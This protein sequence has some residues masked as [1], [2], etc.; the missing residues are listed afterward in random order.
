MKSAS[1]RLCVS[2]AIVLASLFALNV[3]PNPSA[4]AH[5]PSSEISH[6]PVAKTNSTPTIHSPI[7]TKPILHSD[8]TIDIGPVVRNKTLPLDSTNAPRRSIAPS[9]TVS[10]TVGMTR[11][12]VVL[13]DVFGRYRLADY[14]VRLISDTVEVWVQ[15]DL[16]YRNLDGSINVIHPDSR[17]PE[18][19]TQAKIE[20]LAK[21]TA[22]KIIPTDVDYFGDYD[23]RDGSQSALA[24]QLGFPDGY[25]S[26]PGKRVIILVSNVR[27]GNFYDPVNNASFIAG[28]YSGQVNAFADRNII[29]IRSKQWNT[30]VGS[31]NFDYDSTIAHEFQHL[32]N[33]DHDPDEDSWANEGASEFAEFINGYRPSIDSHRTEFSDYPENS[34]TLWGDQDN[35]PDQ[36]FEI[37]ADYQE[38]YWFQLYLAGRLREAGIGT[39][40]NQFL[41]HVSQ[42][43]LDDR[44]GIDAVNAMLTSVGAPFNFAQVWSD[45][46]SAMLFGGTSDATSWGNYISQYVAPSGVPIAP[47]DLGR[48]RRNL[49]FEGYDTEGAPPYGS[50]YIEI[51]WSPAINA[52]TLLT[53]NG[54]TDIPSD[55]KV[56]SAASTEITPTGAVSGN[57]LYS[58][59]TD[60]TD[61]F[62]IFQV[63]VPG[64]GNQTLSFDTL[65]NIEQDWDFGFVQAT[66][67]ITGAAGFTS[68]PISGT[69]SISNTDALPV[70]KANVPGFSGV[71]GSE[72][73]PSWVNITYNLSA[74][75]GKTILLA[76]RYST[77]SGSAGT[78][79]PPPEAGWYIDNLKVGTNALYTNESS[80]P[81]GAK[82][83]W[84]ARNAKN[85]FKLDFATFADGNGD[86]IASVS[87]VTLD[88]NGDGT[89]NL[90]NLL[91][92]SGFNGPGER[93]I[94]LV[95]VIPPSTPADLISAPS[96][97]AAYHL[98]GLP[99][100]LYTSKA[101]GIGTA[102]NSTLRAPRVF[103][104]DTFDVSVVVD[105]LG[106]TSNLSASSGPAF[107]AVPIPANT[108]LVENSLKADIA[109]SSFV[110]APSL[111]ALDSGLPAQ[112]GVYWTGT[113]TSTANLTFTLKTAN[114]LAIGTVIT[115]E[116][117]IANGAF[118]TNPSQNFTDFE[119]PVTVVSPF[120]L[121][122]ATGPSTVQL[123][124]TATYTYTLINTDDVTRTVDFKFTIPTSTTLQSVVVSL[125]QPDAN[126]AATIQ[127]TINTRSIDVP[128][129]SETGQVVQVVIKLRVGLDFRGLTI[130]PQAVI[131]QPGSNVPYTNLALSIPGGVSAIT[132]RIYLPV[133]AKQ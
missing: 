120:A 43:T 8:G 51:G 119:T 105:N 50:D 133:I 55:W 132:G 96:S 109:P 16:R 3:T 90:G 62:L 47:L 34:L 71:S 25:F 69:T 33:A 125:E 114:V 82:S 123:G 37:L 126:A 112:P 117:H 24:N 13:D 76:F 72:D 95:S 86:A 19:I 9:Q 106:R 18:Y 68:L 30:R 93:A 129:F 88:A 15:R 89:F 97:Y 57:V 81:A 21:A 98:T 53:F 2:L 124:S 80:L 1:L 32:I 5:I 99:P 63:A 102:S 56:I 7:S 107:V 64:S 54:D 6:N 118:N 77:D 108:S 111:Q 110:F 92:E 122:T 58:G 91:A 103:P 116:V 73:N 23:S 75:A 35:D 83:I 128:P 31:P 11:T 127:D 130:D 22:D 45:F 28:F 4:S 39:T 17:D 40:N 79:A 74:Y 46:R 67:D 87:S 66:E 121:S 70:I 65:Y 38:A 27:D 100:S 84:Q 20:A 36:D 78:I 85:N 115:P 41:K 94:A 61:N 101:R 104:G 10:Y 52:G 12:F 48:L 26:G 113:V 131:L 29:T 59:H 44:N 42:M 14:D 49:D 60:Y